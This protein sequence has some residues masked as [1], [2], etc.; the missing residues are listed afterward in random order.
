MGDDADGDARAVTVQYRDLQGEMV[1]VTSSTRIARIFEGGVLYVTSSAAP[2]ALVTRRS[3]SA[4]SSTRSQSGRVRAPI[5]RGAMPN[6]DRGLVDLS[7]ASCCGVQTTYGGLM[8]T[9]HTSSAQA[10]ELKRQRR[11]ELER[12]RAAKFRHYFSM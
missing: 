12:L 6:E 10:A 11:A 8:L 2:T 7:L 1:Q 5:S 3:S 4:S 9:S